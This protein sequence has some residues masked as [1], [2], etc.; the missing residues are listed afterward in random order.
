MHPDDQTEDP[1]TGD[2]PRVAAIF[3]D[4][5]LAGYE[6]GVVKSKSKVVEMDI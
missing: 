3:D 1:H 5:K 2:D 4:V 6:M